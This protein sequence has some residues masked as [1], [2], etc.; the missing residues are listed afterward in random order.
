MD[1][2]EIISSI[3]RSI[4]NTNL[5]NAM[6]V[7]HSIRL[8]A[9]NEKS[10]PKVL[11]IIEK[12]MSKFKELGD[13]KGLVNLYGLQILQLE[14]LKEN[15]PIVIE[16]LSKMEN[17]ALQLNYEE[18]LALSFCYSWYIEKFQGNKLE[19]REK[20]SKAIDLINKQRPNDD[21]I[22]YFIRYSQGI[23]E[24]IENHN[25]NSARI[26]EDCIDYFLNNG[27]YRSLAQTLGILLIIYQRTQNSKKV[28]DISKRL[29]SNKFIF[30]KYPEDIQAISYYL[31]GLGQLLIH[32]LKH[33]EN[34]FE[35]SNLIFNKNL[36]GSNYYTYHYCRLLSH[37]ASINALQGKLDESFE[38]IKKIDG[39]LVEKYIIK[40]MDEYSKKQVP[41][42]LNLIKFYVYSR[43]FGFNHKIVQELNEKIY[44]GIKDNYSDSIILGEFILNAELS[45]EQLISLKE[46]ENASIIRVGN[47]VDYAIERIKRKKTIKE[48]QYNRF[49]SILKN[50]PA[51]KDLSYTENAFSDLLIAQELYSLKRYADIYQLLKKYEENIEKID[52]LEMRIY[53]EAFIQV[54]KFK[55]GNP[56]APALHFMAIKRCRERNF[57]RLEGILLDQQKTLQK[58]ALNA[59]KY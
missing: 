35:E 23:E 55:N 37:I 18:G 22:Y 57:G 21:Y 36:K 34:L 31:A 19:S 10:N 52:V 44:T 20:I 48:K 17:L 45:Y 47:I 58:I 54:G 39:L 40:N 59:L 46:I 4:E 5:D 53:M 27:F 56:L 8:F 25:T 28:V 29:F 1:R 26:L 50:K 15:I 12:A 11:Y 24:W 2:E 33:A 3:E 30:S 43:I 6:K 16:I 51:I 32:N 49:I 9:S 41:H 38:I 13:L 7:L 42:T 14:H